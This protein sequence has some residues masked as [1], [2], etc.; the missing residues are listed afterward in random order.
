[1]EKIILNQKSYFASYEEIEKF[2]D[3]LKEYKDGII[4]IPSFIHVHSFLEKGYIVGCQNVSDESVG[5]HTGE[6]SAE[7]LKDIK[8]QYILIG[9]S[10]IR[11]KYKE[12][13][14][15]I[16]NKISRALENGLKVILCIGESIEEKDNLNTLSVIDDYLDDIP[17]NV[18]V[19]YEP[20]WSIGSNII[21]SNEEIKIIVK[22]IKSKG[23]N[24]VLYGG[25]VNEVTIKKLKEVKELDGFLIGEAGRDYLKVIEM[26]EVLSQ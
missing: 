9:H 26:I 15:R 5:S 25:S 24:K 19:S 6:I 3:N 20:I 14:S 1:M 22:H 23:F 11:R 7:A 4:V 10:E 12:E 13:N 21:P 17:K 8:V 16:K 18:V 2:S